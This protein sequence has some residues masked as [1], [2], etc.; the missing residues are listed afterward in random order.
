MYHGATQPQV[1]IQCKMK[2]YLKI[3]P[4]LR[5]PSTKCWSYGFGVSSS[6]IWL[7]GLLLSF[8]ECVLFLILYGQCV[9]HGR[10]IINGL[11]LNDSKT[12]CPQC[13]IECKAKAGCRLWKVRFFP[14][15]DW[16]VRKDSVEEIV[17]EKPSKEAEWYKNH[18]GKGKQKCAE[19]KD[20]GVM[21][22]QGAWTW[23]IWRKTEEMGSRSLTWKPA[24]RGCTSI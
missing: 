5:R 10:S 13:L 23:F 12:E 14:R 18:L 1:H 24:L 3:C 9:T 7:F 11:W 21:L 8:G 22:K 17:L 2:G 4:H 15:V 6:H 16:L 20:Q 19:L